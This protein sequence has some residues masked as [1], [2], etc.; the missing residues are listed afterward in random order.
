MST[1]E[2]T[3]ESILGGINKLRGTQ[4]LPKLEISSQELLGA[5]RTLES[6]TGVAH[7]LELGPKIVHQK[8]LELFSMCYKCH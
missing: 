7:G 5:Q 4:K 3:S 6:V 1:D 8:I 2:I